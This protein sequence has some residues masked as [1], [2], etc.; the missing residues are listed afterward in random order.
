MQQAA[1]LKKATVPVVIE[2]RRNG[3]RVRTVYRLARV[4][5]EGAE[6]LARIRN[7]SDDGMKI[8]LGLEVALNQRIRVW[9][10]DTI[11]VDGQVV[12]TS[13][14]ECGLKFPESVDS[15]GLLRNTAEQIRAGEARAPRIGTDLRAVVSSQQG[16]RPARVHD[17]S[18][19]GMKLIHD[20]SFT[21]GLPVKVTLES[22]MERR[23]VVRWVEDQFAG[24]LLTETFSVEE[25]KTINVR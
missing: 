18:Q 2:D 4:Q 24:L 10:S 25:L 5:A 1:V 8:D 9:L 21:P 16:I 11:S 22:G 23:G 13:D 15:V 20:G 14:N 6:G 3:N 19:R 12:W 17:V 7:L